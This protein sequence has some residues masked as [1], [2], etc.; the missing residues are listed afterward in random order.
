MGHPLPVPLTVSFN[1]PRCL[2]QGGK[3]ILQGKDFFLRFI[4]DLAP[5]PTLNPVLFIY[6]LKNHL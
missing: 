3:T 4:I 2:F 1:Q 5:T 6:S